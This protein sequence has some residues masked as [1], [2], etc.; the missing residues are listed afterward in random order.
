[1]RHEVTAIAAAALLLLGATPQVHAHE[2]G[3]PFSGAIIDPLST[4]HAHLEDEQRINL[5]FVKGARDANGNKRFAFANELELAWARQ[6]TIGAEMFVP[7][8]NGSRNGEYN[9]GDV[10]IQPLKYSF[11]RKP[12]TIATAVLG[13]V[14]PTGS[15]EQGLG[16]GRTTIEPRLYLDQAFG[17]WYLGA[18]LIPA[19]AVTGGQRVSLEYQVAVSYSFIRATGDSAV[20]RPEQ[21]WVFSPSV[22]VVGDSTFRGDESGRTELSLLPG[23]TLWHTHSGWQV[24]AGMLLPLREVRESDVVGLVQFG[25]HFNWGSLLGS[26]EAPQ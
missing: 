10:E 24:H 14:L 4:H 15:V 20:P 17:N 22:E 26:A 21:P 12:E 6:F 16:E 11:V 25:N 3:A 23:L 18:N 5:L 7:F 9:I 8:S 19:Y 2:E 13:A 1:M